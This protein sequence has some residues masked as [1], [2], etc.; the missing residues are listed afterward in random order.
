MTRFAA[1]PTLTLALARDLY[2]EV[3]HFGKDGVYADAWVAF[4]LG[5]IPMPFPNTASRV[6]AVRFHD[7]HHVLTGYDTDTLGE[8]EI[9]AWELAT[10]CA[11]H[12]A[13]WKLNL[14]GMAFGSLWKP[15]R[16]WSAFLRG[17]HSQNLYRETYG[18]ALLARTV[19]E[20]RESLGLVATAAAS[21]RASDVALFA[22]YLVAGL[23]V[24]L[25]ML[26]FV[27][28]M[29]IVA[30]IAALFRRPKGAPEVGSAA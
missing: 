4:S 23:L 25:A 22:A 8:L 26:P 7:L 30:N 9:S 20:A 10:G 18:D 1:D 5:P 12:F 28:P 21:T 17:R 27:V 29:A 14:G 2:F 24:G 15:R 6:R 11:D 16:I 3:N 13:A 19:G